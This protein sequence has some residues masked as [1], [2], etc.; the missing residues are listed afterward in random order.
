MIHISFVKWLHPSIQ[1]YQRYP[2]EFQQ[3]SASKISEEAPEIVRNL[4]SFN[5]ELYSVNCMIM[6]LVASERH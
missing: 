1:Q 4:M 5:I 2:K 3:V 6:A